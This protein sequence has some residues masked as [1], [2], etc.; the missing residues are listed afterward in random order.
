MRNCKELGRLRKQAL[1]GS[2]K[3]AEAELQRLSQANTDLTDQINDQELE[4]RDLK[5]TIDSL[6]SDLSDVSL[7]LQKREEVHSAAISELQKRMTMTENEQIETLTKEV[8]RW[9][10]RHL[11]LQ[12]EK[13]TVER[14][15][16]GETGSLEDVYKEAEAAKRQVATELLELSAARKKLEKEQK[17]VSDLRAQLE[18]KRMVEAGN[19]ATQ[20]LQRR[21]AVLPENADSLVLYLDAVLTEA[22]KGIVKAVKGEEA[23]NPSE[24]KEKLRD[25]M[26]RKR[27]GKQGPEVQ[28][29][30]RLLET[31]RDNQIQRLEAVETNEAQQT[32]LLAYQLQSMSPARSLSSTLRRSPPASSFPSL[33]STA[34][35]DGRS[36]SPVSD[37]TNAKTRLQELAQ[38]VS[39]S[40]STPKFDKS[41]SNPISFPQNPDKLHLQSSRKDE[42]QQFIERGKGGK[43]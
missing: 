10:D 6:N 3:D 8:A 15:W 34:R 29:L 11:A 43:P 14:M 31:L 40:Q 19:K 5:A 20:G 28:M 13:E 30:Q 2:S 27:E 41:Q 23:G 9:R 1:I 37:K 25:K 36:V 35:K 16:K 17:V 7:R 33:L 22:A 32:R 39:H 12:E 21:E 24:L 26:E 4:I 38:R 18:A 42:F